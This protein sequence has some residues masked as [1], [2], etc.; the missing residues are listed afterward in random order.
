MRSRMRFGLFLVCI[1]LGSLPFSAAQEQ[2]TLNAATRAE[3]DRIAHEVLA[4]TGVPSASLAIV[5]DAQIVYVQAYGNA[6]LDPPTPARPEMHYSIGSISK[7]FTATAILI[8][9]EQGKLSLDDLV[10]RFLPNL[11]RANEVTV[12][13]LLSHTSG[14]QDYWPQDY[15]PPM[16]QVDI[17]AEQILE[18]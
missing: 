2:S 15:S 8:L 1:V 12:R 17:T 7:Q 10:A 13:E 11:T 3:I 6:K 9:A 4:Q 14:Y 18:R 16:M 5:K